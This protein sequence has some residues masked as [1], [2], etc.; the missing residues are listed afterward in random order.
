ML[1]WILAEDTA[2]FRLLAENLRMFGY[3]ATRLWEKSAALEE[4]KKR[5]FD[6][7]LCGADWARGDGSAVLDALAAQGV[8]VVFVSD[9]Q[10]TEEAV[11]PANIRELI[12]R[13]EAR[14]GGDQQ[15]PRMI[16]Y[17]RVTVDEARRAVTLDGQQVPLKQME[18][19]LLVTLLRQPGV[20]FAR[21]DLLSQ[22]WGEES[23]ISTRTVD[24]HVAALRRK[25]CLTRELT[26]VYRIGYRFDPMSPVL[27]H[28]A[29]PQ[30]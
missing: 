2:A 16:S 6:V 8:P 29:G 4:I 14:T 5:R 24:V 22:V 25:L 18:Y 7:A 21:A 17:Q 13:M 9:G 3:Q 26:T 15:P 19:R 20:T 10:G 23:A 1:V 12:R 27:E 11:H 28:D 30:S